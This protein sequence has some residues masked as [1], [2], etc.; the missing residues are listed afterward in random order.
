[1]Q[2][3]IKSI[4]INILLI[5]A[6]CG[7]LWVA[8]VGFIGGPARAYEKDD[9]Y[10]VEAYLQSKNYD[11]AQLLNRFSYDKVYYIIR[12]RHDGDEKLA[13]F[14]KD[15]ETDGNHDLITSEEIESFASSHEFTMSNINYGVY[16]SKL[17]FVY[18]DSNKEYF[19]DVDTL[20]LIYS[21]E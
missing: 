21:R 1:M 11:S 9:T 18:K 5:A 2:T 14:S 20:E 16:D 19:Y 13:W 12:Y 7:T 17:I 8:Y 4:L 3:K 15:F 6:I 10:H